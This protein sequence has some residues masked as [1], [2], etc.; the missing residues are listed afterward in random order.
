MRERTLHLVFLFVL[1][2]STTYAQVVVTVAGVPESSG[3]LDGPALQSLFNNPHGI[4]V[5][6]EAN[7]YVA[8][9]FGHRIR[10]ISTD[11]IV[12]TVAGSGVAGRIDGQGINASFN[13]PWGICVGTDGNIYVADTRNNLIRKI[14]N[15]GNV[16][17]FAGSGNYGT[18]NG[19][20]TSATFG[21]P[22]GIEMDQF[23]NL[24]VADHL[25]H[26][27]RKITPD[28]VVSTLAGTA[29]L[30]G[31]VDGPGF[32]ARFNRPYG[33]TIDNDG[34]IIVADEW[35]HLIRKITPDGVTTTIAGT[36]TVG[37]TDG[38]A[39]LASFNF[40]WDVTVDNDGNIFVADGYNKVI[41]KIDMSD[42]SIPFVRNFAGIVGTSGAIDGNALNA[43]F[44]GVTSLEFSKST[45]EIYI[46]DAYNHLVRKIINLSNTTLTLQVE[47]GKS[48]YCEGETVAI[49]AIPSNFDQYQF[50]VDGVLKQDSP[51]ADFSIATLTV[52]VHIIKAVV[53]DGTELRYSNE[54]NISVLAPPQVTITQ[55]GELE[56]FEGDSVILIASNGKQYLWSNNQ[57]TQAITVKTSGQYF[58]QLTNIAGCT[59]ISDTLNVN[60]I[61]VVEQPKVEIV[62]GDNSFCFGETAQLRSSYASNNQWFKDGWPIDGQTDQ[63]LEV[64]AGGVYEVR[65]KDN[66]G[67]NLVSNQV[68]LLFVPK[69]IKDFSIDNTH[70]TSQNPLVNFVAQTNWEVTLKWDFGDPSSGILNEA[71]GDNSSHSY[72]QE[73]EYTVSLYAESM[74]DCRELLAKENIIIY[75]KDENGTKDDLFI[76]SAFTPNGDGIND[77]L[78]VRGE[79]IKKLEFYICNKWG[80]LIFQSKNQS[81]GWDGKLNGQLV[82]TGTYTYMLNIEKSDGQS[83]QMIGHVTVLR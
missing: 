12:T 83:Q 16:S 42:P 39:D 9:R 5:D 68:E 55:V 53:K 7:V 80:E 4:A 20:A 50:Y 58:V 46:G 27:I 76:P 52:G 75:T 49:Q 17:T 82:Q 24:Y 14:D 21:N 54:V 62:G 60:V 11:G 1:F 72:S 3:Y 26:I 67:A 41:R 47:Q 61:P 71:T 66:S 37:S 28:R 43:R 35:N 45:D 8:D 40:P 77:V 38:V 81:D 10:K 74:E 31:A 33:L 23:G 56:F 34:N 6:S 78:F 79:H 2:I 32:T 48:I 29:Y 30:P 65:V 59:G 73:G 22:T 64:T 19:F 57:T 63:I 15:N 25:T 13:E 44:R 69:L 70:P 51:E 18:S 36:G